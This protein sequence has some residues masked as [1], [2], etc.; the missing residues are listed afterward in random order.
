MTSSS[1]PVSSP[2]R[3]TKR[4]PR[5]PR[6]D[7]PKCR[8]VVLAL[9][10]KNRNRQV[11]AGWIADRNIGY[12]EYAI[13]VSLRSLRKDKRVSRIFEHAGGFPYWVWPPLPEPKDADAPESDAHD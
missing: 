6:E 1:Q 4:A 8:K 11:T 3:T 7:I 2:P 5:Q 13:E 10:Q 9:L 12:S